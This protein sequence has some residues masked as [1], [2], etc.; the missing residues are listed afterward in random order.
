MSLLDYMRPLPNCPSHHFFA[1]VSYKVL[2]GGSPS[3][4]HSLAIRGQDMASSR[5]SVILLLAIVRL[6]ARVS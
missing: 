2:S 6:V 3:L 5:I 4:Q 1:K